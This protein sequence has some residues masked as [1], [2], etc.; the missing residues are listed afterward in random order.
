MVRAASHQILR[1]AQT[2][3]E[4]DLR[5][6]SSQASSRQVQPLRSSSPHTEWQS[7]ILEELTKTSKRGR[8]LPTPR[9]KKEPELSPLNLSCEARAGA[10]SAIERAPSRD[11]SDG[12]LLPE[13]ESPQELK[14]PP[15][16]DVKL[17]RSTSEL[18][19]WLPD[20]TEARMDRINTAFQRFKD[21]D[22]P[23]IHKDELPKVLM[24]LGYTQIHD[25]R[26][27]DLAD[28]ITR[29]PMLEKAEFITFMEKHVEYE[30]HAFRDIFERFDADGNGCLDAGELHVFLSSLGFTPLRS[31]IRERV[32]TCEVFLIPLQEDGNGTLD[33]EETVILMH[34]ISVSLVLDP[35]AHV[36]E[37]IRSGR[38]KSNM[39]PQ[40]DKGP[41]PALTF[42]EAVLW[43][44]RFRERMFT[45]Y[46]DV[47]DRFDDDG[48]DNI[49]LREIKNVIRELGFTI[50]QKTVHELILEARRRGDILNSDT[51]WLDYDSFVHFMQLLNENDGFN[52]QEIDRIAKT[53][54]K[55]DKDGSGD[56]NTLELSDMMRE[57]PQ[58]PLI[59]EMGQAPRIEEVRTLLS[60][61][62]IN[63]NGVLD[64][65]EFIRFSR[66]FREKQLA[67]A[68]TLVWMVFMNHADRQLCPE[69]IPASQVDLAIHVLL[70]DEAIEVAPLP[71]EEGPPKDQP[72]EFDEF[73]LLT[74]EDRVRERLIWTSKKFAGF[75]EAE[76]NEI[77]QIFDSFD[78]K[79]AGSLKPNE[80][81]EL[82]KSLGIEV[83]SVEERIALSEQIATA[84]QEAQEAGAE[85]VVEGQVNF[86]VFLQLFRAMKRKQD[87]E[88]ERRLMSVCEEVKFNS[89]ERVEGGSQPVPGSLRAVLVLTLLGRS[90]FRHEADTK[91]S[92]GR[93]RQALDDQLNA[94][95]AQKGIDFPNFLLLMRWM[96]DVDFCS[97]S[98]SK[99]P[100]T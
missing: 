7:R 74:S 75:G 32:S 98:S 23:E 45:S 91:E 79:R 71:P 18:A 41:P 16:N 42:Q 29:Y 46:R 65:R 36:K 85:A 60:A 73:G 50:P 4:D 14:R 5:P 72:I 93:N 88:K 92:F 97:I 49:D 99:Q 84:C 22:N 13:E 52:K 20:I 28:G 82:L 26:V 6:Q 48:N 11:C 27:R 25:A 66:L 3:R 80:A 76:V 83:R 12:K 9:Y 67:R 61:V 56:I 1:R 51:D 35:T 38:R 30:L 21:P 34:A 58:L 17:T 94:L 44:R 59:C 47:F 8:A 43:A 78:T 90:D 54:K 77:R 63:G 55:Y 53:F 81:S 69:M 62:D 37:I 57:L 39:D 100:G 96:L 89:Q 86:W 15:Q 10:C 24:H 40:G 31:I 68:K 70:A 95:Q 64:E 2:P 87:E 33:F 19:Q